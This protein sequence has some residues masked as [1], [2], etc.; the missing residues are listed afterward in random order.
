MRFRARSASAGKS[1]GVARGTPGHRVTWFLMDINTIHAAGS[2]D[3]K[4]CLRPLTFL[5]SLSGTEREQAQ[6]NA[7]V[8]PR[9]SSAST[10]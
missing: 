2:M 4:L 5:A 3:G 6:A 8:S 10:A 9:L 1:G 7:R